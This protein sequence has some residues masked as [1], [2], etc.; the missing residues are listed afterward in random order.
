MNTPEP[1]GHAS[2][3]PD[4]SAASPRNPRRSRRFGA[5]IAAAL[6]VIAGG[7][8]IAANWEPQPNPASRRPAMSAAPSPGSCLV[9]DG[10]C[11][12]SLDGLNDGQVLNGKRIIAAGIRGNV[13]KTGIV[14]ALAAALRDTKMTNYANSNVSESLT[15]SHDSVGVDG[16]SVGVFAQVGDSATLADRMNPTR[17]AQR[18]FGSMKALADWEL[19]T[20]GQ[21]AQQVQ[22]SAFPNGYALEVPRAKAFYLQNVAAV[23]DVVC[24]AG[25]PLILDEPSCSTA[26]EPA[27]MPAT[28]VP[29]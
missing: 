9:E 28:V 15:Y 27:R 20:P 25:E 10:Q 24:P 13:N 22:R 21:I 6:A 3:E 1:S 5:A 19:M 26:P 8:L 12:P 23:H 16:S 7:A 18:F 17:A 11:L 2:V 29:R 4:N 14:A